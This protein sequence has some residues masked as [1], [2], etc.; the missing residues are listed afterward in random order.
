MPEPD[1]LQPDDLTIERTTELDLDIDE[2][3][4]LI[5]T[6]RGWSSWLV[7]ETDL[8]VRPGSDGMAMQ[9]GAERAVHI[10]TVDEGR[11]VA[12]SWWDRDDPSSASFVRL[13]IVE[14]PSG[15]SQLHI[16]ERFLGATARTTS[17][18]IANE[19]LAWQVRFVSLW[20]LALHSTVLA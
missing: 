6:P 20:L 7:D 17:S 9:D 18:S 10:E 4:T 12:F 15:G 2:L 19:D 16:S 3:W 5:S 11:G 14:L 8:A 1:E 13:D